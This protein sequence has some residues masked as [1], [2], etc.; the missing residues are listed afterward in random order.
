[1]DGPSS[2][3]AGEAWR[4]ISEVALDRDRKIAASQTLGLSWTRVLALRQLATQ[5]RTQRELAE[6]LAA[7]PPYVTLIVDDLEERGL[8]RRTPHP[9]DRRANL[10]QLTPAGHSA[11][12]LADSI[13]HE[14]PPALHDV[15]A[16]DLAAVLRVLG[17]LAHE[18]PVVGDP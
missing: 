13:L 9:T 6:R 8:A 2:D 3:L 14:P 18:G 5:P 10:V 12:E 4:A 1:M 15:P 7:D 16:E 17:R 11:A